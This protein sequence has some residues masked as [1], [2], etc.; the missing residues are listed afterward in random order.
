VNA[1]VQ[2]PT[3]TGFWGSPFGL[4]IRWATYIPAGAAMLKIIEVLGIVFLQWL[5]GDMRG[6]LIMLLFGGLVFMFFAVA[7]YYFAYMLVVSMC[8]SPR[9]GMVVFTALFLL[10]QVFALIGGFIDFPVKQALVIATSAVVTSAIGMVVTI[11]AW[12]S[13]LPRWVR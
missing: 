7:L 8:P 1:V 10:W 5:Y 12:H 11:Q 2:P 9:A 4:A 6:F 3:A 13:D